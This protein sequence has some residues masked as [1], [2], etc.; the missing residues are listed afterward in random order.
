MEMLLL[1]KMKPSSMVMKMNNL[2]SMTLMMMKMRMKTLKKRKKNLMKNLRVKEE[3]R[4]NE[5]DIASKSSS[6]NLQYI[7]I[8]Q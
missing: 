2:K 8:K 1:I 7:S 5:H 6:P 4:K 3:E